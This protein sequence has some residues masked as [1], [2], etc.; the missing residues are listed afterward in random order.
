MNQKDYELQR[1][2]NNNK[3]LKNV[4]AGLVSIAI[5][6]MFIKFNNDHDS[7]IVSL[8]TVGFI[9]F[10]VNSLFLLNQAAN[11]FENRREY[12]KNVKNHNESIKRF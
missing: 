5:F 8:D 6:Y 7:S 4:I 1:V 10:V 9:F 11:F 2:R 3:I 12:K